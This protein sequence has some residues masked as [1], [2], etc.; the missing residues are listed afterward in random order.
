MKKILATAAVI[1]MTATTQAHA[2]GEREQGILTGVIG[3]II[4][5]D[6]YGNRNHGHHGGHNGGHNGGQVIIQ[7]APP[8]YNN[9]TTVIIQEPAWAS[10]R[11]CSE[12]IVRHAN[13]VQS[14]IQKNCAGRVVGIIDYKKY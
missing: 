1:A 7:Q 8:V 11:V 5:Q 10:Q 6:I 4:L 2:W 14:T 13:G 3:T 12:E 9:H